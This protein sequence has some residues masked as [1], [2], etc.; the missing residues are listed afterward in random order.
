LHEVDGQR[1]GDILPTRALIKT[2]VTAFA[3]NYTIAVSPDFPHLISA[4]DILIGGN[5]R[6][7][8]V[9]LPNSSEAKRPEQLLS[10]LALSRLG[11]PD[12][13]ICALILDKDDSFDSEDSD[14][15]TLK[16]HFDISLISRQSNSLESFMQGEYTPRHL[17]L[18]TRQRTLVR[19]ARLYFEN[20]QEIAKPKRPIRASELFYD[21]QIRGGYEPTTV[22]SWLRQNKPLW[23]NA[24]ETFLI[25]R[26]V[27]ILAATFE[28]KT[29]SLLKLR[30]FCNSAVRLDYSLD[31]GVPYFTNPTINI[32]LV[33][34][35]PSYRLDPQKPLRASAFAGLV[36]LRA[37]SIDEIE[38][39]SDR[40]EKSL[41]RIT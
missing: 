27:A 22:Q 34:R 17:S 1:E 20:Q 25:R 15:Q 13:L 4:P 26:N 35:V 23:R 32:L 41:G 37:Q 9:F 18:E 24:A 8:A 2:I 30:A 14:W 33:D 21:I 6:L 11:L 19:Y 16:W 5:G 39:F 12:H 10:R 38:R 3:R 28:D 36:F 29:S 7:C 31:N 40:L